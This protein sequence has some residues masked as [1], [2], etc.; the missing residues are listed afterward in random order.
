MSEQSQPHTADTTDTAV[1]RVV[2]FATQWG[3]YYAGESAAFNALDAAA[4]IDLKVATEGGASGHPEAEREERERRE[5][6]LRRDDLPRGGV[7]VAGLEFPPRRYVPD[8]QHLDVPQT[9]DPSVRHQLDRIAR[10]RAAG[11]PGAAAQEDLDRAIDNLNKR[12]EARTPHNPPLT[13]P[14]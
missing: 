14:V 4:L 5:G 3:C 9:Y 13:D 7:M 1:T 12:R 8:P 10:D 6:E 11:K 2:T